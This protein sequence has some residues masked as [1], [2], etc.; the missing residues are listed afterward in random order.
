M[1]EPALT[2]RVWRKLCHIL[3]AWRS[4]GDIPGMLVIFLPRLTVSYMVVTVAQ[5]ARAIARLLG[6]SSSYEPKANL[7]ILIVTDYMPPQT[8]GIAI[9][10]RNYIDNM[11]LRGH[12][13]QVFSTNITKDRE[14]SFDHPNLPAIVNPFNTH[15]KMAYN[16]GV[17]L[18][19]YLG[20]KQCDLV[21]PTL[22]LTQA[23]NPNNPRIDP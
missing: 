11:R 15:N 17:K 4:A 22:T 1:E 16:P 20:A 23:S 13:V 3:K 7:R 9:R 8:H 10:F 12:E 18:S 6:T 14:T 5:M 2:V 19:Y 21:H